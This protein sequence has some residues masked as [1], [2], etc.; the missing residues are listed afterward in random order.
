MV[1]SWVMHN[2]GKANVDTI[3]HPMTHIFMDFGELQVA[4]LDDSTAYLSMNASSCLDELG[5]TVTLENKSFWVY[6]VRNTQF[7]LFLFWLYRC[8]VCKQDSE[9][10]EYA[11]FNNGKREVCQADSHISI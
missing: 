6:R 10:Q 9:H 7:F 5:L 11:A 3:D 8:G 1:K 2:G 4:P